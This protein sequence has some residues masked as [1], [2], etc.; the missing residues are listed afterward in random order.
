MY[1]I[2]NFTVKL[3]PCYRKHLIKSVLLVFDSGEFVDYNNSHGI[4]PT[5][6]GWLG[7]GFCPG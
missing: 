2:V 5:V 7:K 3:F 1:E 6:W 4:C